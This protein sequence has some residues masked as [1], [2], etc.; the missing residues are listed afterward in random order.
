[1]NGTIERNAA[2]AGDNNS[3]LLMTFLNFATINSVVAIFETVLVLNPWRRRRKVNPNEATEKKCTSCQVTLDSLFFAFSL[4]ATITFI[5]IMQKKF[6]A[7]YPT[8]EITEKGNF[9]K[10]LGFVE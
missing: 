1:M 4:A 9:K 5:V 8:R 2:P 6:E 3:P 10:E 7:Q